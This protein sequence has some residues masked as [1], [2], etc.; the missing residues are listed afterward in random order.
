M[1]SALEGWGHCLVPQRGL[2]GTLD[3]N[4]GK[5]RLYVEGHH[6]LVVLDLLTAD[7]GCEVS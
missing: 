6:D 3:R 5:Q 7:D 2:Y 4:V 1:R